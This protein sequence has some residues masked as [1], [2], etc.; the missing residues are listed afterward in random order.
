[1]MQPADLSAF[2]GV[3][4]QARGD[5]R[6]HRVLVFSQAHGMMP[7]THEFTPGTDWSLFEVTWASLGI[8]G[9][10]VSAI[11]FVGAP[12]AGDFWFDID[13]VRLR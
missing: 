7:L 12:P 10:D 11:L 9:S 2:D 13:D 4:F 8:D 6:T 1:M 5:G 3:R